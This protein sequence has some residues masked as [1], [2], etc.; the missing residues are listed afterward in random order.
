MPRQLALAGSWGPVPELQMATRPAEEKLYW[1]D[2][3]FAVMNRIP[4]ETDARLEV[5]QCGIADVKLTD[6]VRGRTSHGPQVT[7]FTVYLCGVGLHL[8]TSPQ[9]QSQT[10]TRMPIVLNIPA[11]NFIAHIVL[12]T[13]HKIGGQERR[14]RVIRL[15]NFECGARNVSS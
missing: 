9:I 12:V 11:K 13:R 15:Q 10:G 1:V 8:I 5:L 3:L 7:D 4:C 2:R 6:E 14:A